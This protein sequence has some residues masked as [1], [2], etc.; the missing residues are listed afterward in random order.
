[1]FGAL[2]ALDL[3]Q[4]HANQEQAYA[5]LRVAIKSGACLLQKQV[6]VYTRDQNKLMFM[7]EHSVIIIQISEAGRELSALH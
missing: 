5:T 4:R 7:R 3:T 2:S 6:M 1:L